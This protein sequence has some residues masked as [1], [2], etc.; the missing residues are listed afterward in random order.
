MRNPFCRVGRRRHTCA[1]A[2]HGEPDIAAEGSGIKRPPEE[3]ALEHD[4][5]VAEWIRITESSKSAQIA[6]KSKTDSNPKGSGRNES[7]INAATR[8][9]G[10]ERT[11]AQRAVMS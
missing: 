1:G 6:P 11:K 8:E 2:S 3:A 5:H 7:G 10:I 4:E 9:L